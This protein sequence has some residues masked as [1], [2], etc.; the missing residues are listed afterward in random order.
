M[1]EAVVRRSAELFESGLYCAESV[2]QAVAEARQER[3]DLIP[4]IATG[5]C[6]GVS[7]SCGMC[8]AVSG[9]ILAIGLS[10]G[11]TSPDEPVDPAYRAVRFVLDGFEAE[12]GSSNCESL[13]RCD[14]GT[15]E[16]QRAFEERELFT[17]CTTY[18]ARATHLALEALE[19]PA[20]G[21]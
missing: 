15:D 20:E 10:R 12:F 17:I 21:C 19:Q 3:C 14:L 18:V 9:A 6:S 11:R 4:R 1:N 7:R 8:G 5:F 2:L 13:L 16:G